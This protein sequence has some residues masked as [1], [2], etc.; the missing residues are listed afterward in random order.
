MFS[1]DDFWH[2]CVITRPQIV[3]YKCKRHSLHFPLRAREL[4]SPNL[5]S[6]FFTLQLT[7]SLLSEAHRDSCSPNSFILK[8][9]FKS[10]AHLIGAIVFKINQ[11]L[12]HVNFFLYF[13]TFR[14]NAFVFSHSAMFTLV[15]L[16][17]RVELKVLNWQPARATAKSS[18]SV[19]FV[20]I[21]HIFIV[22]YVN[23][24][25]VFSHY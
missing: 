23:H 15:W 19:T 20:S 3:S 18:Q 5:R 16:I 2:G 24:P 21:F 6:K 25:I 8:S 14:Y 10:H 17:N 12:H 4:L 7:W 13:G 9:T 22:N 11:R 1:W